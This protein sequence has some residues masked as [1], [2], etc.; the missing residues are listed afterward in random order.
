MQPKRMTED[1][2]QSTVYNAITEAVDF[3]ET[4]ISP[5]RIEA[6]LYFDG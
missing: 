1:E 4:E 3:V 5:D 6:Q 2:I